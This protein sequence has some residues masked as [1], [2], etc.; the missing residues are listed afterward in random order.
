VVNSWALAPTGKDPSEPGTRAFLSYD[1]APGATLRDSVTLWN[2]S[3]VPLHFQLYA[4]D[5]F[6]NTKGAFDLLPGSKPPTDV[7]SWVTLTY[8]DV[9]LNPRAKVDIPFTIAVPPTARPGD[10]A[11]AILAANQVQG[12]GPDGK[13]V[14]IDRR[15]GSRMYVRVRG[16]LEPALA[17]EN[18][19]TVY[20]SG[21]SPLGGFD[22][23]Y[24]V[25]NAGNVRLAA[26]RSV[27]AKGP[28]GL[29]T[30]THKLTDLPELLPGNAVTFHEHFSGVPD[31]I[32]ATGAIRLEPFSASADVKAPSVER[33]GHTWAIPWSIVA[34]L[35]IVW[36]ARKAYLAIRQRRRALRVVPPAV[37]EPSPVP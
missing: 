32:R 20:H 9:D 15:T 12:T 23:T 8:T 34:L 27:K 22:V 13:V 24:T 6:N 30:K 25:R 19:R 1:M 14:N 16:P 17:V 3:N 11:A 28:F 31:L 5:A 36:L 29:A 26:H 35:V 33:G 10:H 7:G 18:V 4:T 37:R 21:L 2:Y